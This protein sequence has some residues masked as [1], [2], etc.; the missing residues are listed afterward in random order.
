MRK[1]LKHLFFLL[2]RKTHK[3]VVIWKDGDN[4][5]IISKPRS[6]YEHYNNVPDRF[7]HILDWWNTSTTDKMI[8]KTSTTY[9]ALDRKKIKTIYLEK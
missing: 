1:L 6:P 7:I 2:T 9:L 3:L 8:Y 5:V 4:N